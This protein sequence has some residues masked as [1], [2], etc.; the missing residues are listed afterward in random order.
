MRPECYYCHIKTI[1]KLITKFRPGENDAKNLIFSVH[2]FLGNHR[3]MTNPR[4]AANIHR[5]ARDQLNNP[6][7]YKEEKLQANEL[8]HKNYSYW[9][10]IVN[11]SEN[12]LFTAAKLSVIGN[13]IDYGSHSI[14]GNIAL[15][16]E[17]LFKNDLKI[18]H[19]I[20][21]KKEIEKAK[22]ILYLGDNSGEIVFDMMFIETMKHPNVTF[23]VRD[24]PVIND[25][26]MD[27]ARQIGMENICRVISNGN[28]APSTLP[29]YCSKEFNE[30]FKKADLVIS[31]GQGNFEGL[32][33]C[34]HPN[35]FFLLIAKCEPMGHLLGVSKNDMV[36]TKLK[37]H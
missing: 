35:I 12:P 17:S 1:E 29:E 21:L 36:I 11:S 4:L 14:N 32:L 9:K 7:L 2:E 13:I 20:E 6:D 19:T 31:K 37:N 16:I 30:L 18:D 5:I 22:S 3:K 10:N 27:D 26:T 24:K 25:V 34:D 15:Q 28:D 8:L 23:V 33:E